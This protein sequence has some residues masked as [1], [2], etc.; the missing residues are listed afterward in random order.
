M[1]RWWNF[2]CANLPRTSIPGILH[3]LSADVAGRIAANYV[4]GRRR[5]ISDVLIT[6][7]KNWPTDFGTT[8]PIKMVTAHQ[9]R[10]SGSRLFHAMDQW[11]DYIRYKV[12]PRQKVFVDGRSDFYG[13]V[14]AKNISL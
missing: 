4:L 7:Q 9:D 8:F 3:S 1:T 14:L 6:T 2:F 11:G 12:W 13:Q 5:R 10:L